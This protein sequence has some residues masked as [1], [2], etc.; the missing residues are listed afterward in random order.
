MVA[1]TAVTEAGVEYYIE[2][3]STR[4]ETV[5]VPKGL[6]SVTVTVVKP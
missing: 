1:E 6:P 2:A 3:K 5:R 4:R